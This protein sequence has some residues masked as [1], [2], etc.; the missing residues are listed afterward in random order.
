MIKLIVRASLY[1]QIVVYRFVD[2][3]LPLIDNPQI[4]RSTFENSELNQ[5]DMLA[6]HLLEIETHTK[7][8]QTLIKYSTRLDIRHKSFVEK[9]Q[10]FVNQLKILLDSLDGTCREQIEA[11]NEQLSNLG[12]VHPKSNDTISRDPGE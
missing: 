1:K 5:R 9:T 8:C 3:L 10:V 11:I 12:F 2:V 4:Q 6:V 7:L